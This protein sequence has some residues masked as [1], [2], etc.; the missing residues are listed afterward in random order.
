[1]QAV[2]PPHP[3][4]LQCTQ[5]L[6]G[7]RDQQGSMLSYLDCWSAALGCA[8]LSRPAGA[9]LTRGC[10]PLCLLSPAARLLVLL[11]LCGSCTA[12][13]LYCCSAPSVTE[14]VL[15]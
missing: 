14:G 9:W 11:P 7:S 8:V 15:L 4:C 3:V 5:V 6:L 10:G 1:M 2:T 12:E 13:L